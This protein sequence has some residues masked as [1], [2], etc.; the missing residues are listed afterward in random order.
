MRDRTS[1]WYEGEGNVGISVTEGN[2]KSLQGNNKQQGISANTMLNK[3]H[4][5]VDS[6]PNCC[7][8]RK[9]TM[10]VGKMANEL[11]KFIFE[12]NSQYKSLDDISKHFVQELSGNAPAASE[13]KGDAAFVPN[14]VEVSCDGS[15]SDAGRITVLNAGFGIERA[16]EVEKALVDD[17]S[18]QHVIKYINDDGSVVVCVVS[19]DGSVDDTEISTL[20][21]DAI[22]RDWKLCKARIE[23]IEGYPA[24]RI[25]ASPDMAD[26]PA[27]SCRFRNAHFGLR[28]HVRKAR[29]SLRETSTEEV[30]CS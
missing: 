15:A 17:N 5:R 22:L 8:A 14:V 18:E 29:V 13:K 27:C 24:N 21:M 28:D 2:V 30:V 7:F 23:M 1:H 10:L 3:A 4:A 11:V 6:M 26:S 25:L 12:L 9:K 16:I 20:S 19:P